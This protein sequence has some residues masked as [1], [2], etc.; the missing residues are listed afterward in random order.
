MRC[1]LPWWIWPQGFHQVE[2]EISSRPLTAFRLPEA[3][4]GSALWQWKVMPFGLRNA[5][6]TFQR[7]MTE[8]LQGLE[9]F[10]I[11]YIDD[12][13]IFSHTREQHM[14]HLDKV[15]EALGKASYHVRLQKCDL[16]KQ[17]VNFLGHR[18]TREGITTQQQ[19]SGRFERVENALHNN[20]TSE[21]LFGRFCMVSGLS[22]SLRN[23]SCSVIRV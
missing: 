22:S 12:I 16:V 19:K 6:P 9:D 13:L 18:L 8:A 11:V 7:A 2:V 10:T 21:V 23:L 14:Q 5:P 20:P 17:E 1:I 15:F 4:R 3:V